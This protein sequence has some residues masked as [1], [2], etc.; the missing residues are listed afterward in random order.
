MSAMG[1]FAAR[2]SIFVRPVVVTVDGAGDGAEYEEKEQY[3]DRNRASRDRIH[4]GS[5]T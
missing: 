3:Y 5:E 4:R 1:K 2:L